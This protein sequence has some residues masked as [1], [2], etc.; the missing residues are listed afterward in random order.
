MEV[1]KNRQLYGLLN[2]MEGK[3]RRILEKN[4]VDGELNYKELTEVKDK[5]II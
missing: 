2:Y 1:G 3:L 4:N 5:K